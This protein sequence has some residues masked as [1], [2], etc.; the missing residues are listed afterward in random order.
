MSRSERKIISAICMADGMYLMVKDHYRSRTGARDIRRR[1]ELLHE[2]C[3]MA[4]KVW[5]AQIDAREI[6]RLHE[7]LMTV[8]R[9]C[10]SPGAKSDVCV[11]T[12]LVMGMINDI[13]EKVK[14]ATRRDHLVYVLHRIEKVHGYFDHTGQ[15]WADYERATTAV[16]TWHAMMD[17]AA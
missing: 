15:R 1:L 10:L 11:I 17:G 6:T 7:L 3:D 16:N 5:C 9:A 14:D 4:F 8:E 2:A 12:S 13:L